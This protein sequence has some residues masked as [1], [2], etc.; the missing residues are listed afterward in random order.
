MKRILKAALGLSLTFILAA[1]CAGNVP[2]TAP[3]PTNDDI[4]L[5]A[6]CWSFDSIREN[7]KDIADAGYTIVQTSPAQH[8][9]TGADGDTGGNQLFGQGKWYYHYQPVAWEIGNQHVGTREDLIE[10]CDEAR[11]YGI[12]IIVDVLPNHTSIDES[13]VEPEMIAAVGGPDKLYHANGRVDITDYNDR[14]QCTTGRMGG[15]PDVNTEN[16]DFQVYYMTYVNDLLACGVR[17]FRYDTAKHI[18]LPSDPVDAAS[19]END[20]WDVATGRKSVNGVSLSVPMDE[21]FFYG[22]V[23]QDRNVKE[24]EYAGYMGLTAS[25]MGHC[26]RENLDARSWTASDVTGWSH[27]AD[28]SQL[29]PWVESHDTYCNAHESAHLSDDQIRVAWV[30]LV[31]RQH[32]TPLFY[33]RPDGSDGPAGNIWGNNIAGA[34]GNDAFKHPAVAAANKF[35][36]AMSG[37]PETVTFACEGAVAQVARGTRGSAVL[38]ISAEPQILEAPT[39]LKDGTYCDELSGEV[40]KV[41][42][43]IITGTLAPLGTYILM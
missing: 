21:L 13:Q 18:G 26:L 14:F 34:K 7:L 29:V 40:F 5:H 27:K 9:I 43:G 11:K 33:S 10:L 3:V 42:K 17:G 19:T 4:I 31:A 41:R 23:L 38:N 24:E 35:R 25:S 16:P 37:L 2:D 36:A 8:C 15:L 1:S 39:N 12:R 30:Y 6:W 20:F 32:G 22:E 28:P